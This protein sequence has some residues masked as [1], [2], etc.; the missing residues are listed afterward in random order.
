MAKSSS[1]RPAYV[2]IFGVARP[3]NLGDHDLIDLLRQAVQQAMCVELEITANGM[4]VEC[5][6]AESL[7]ILETALRAKLG[8]HGGRLESMTARRI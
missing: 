7:E 5:E 2:V 3:P 8:A 4:V 1:S 6:A